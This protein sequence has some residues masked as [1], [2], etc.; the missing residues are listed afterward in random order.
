MAIR[1]LHFRNLRFEYNTENKKL[2]KYESYHNLTV[3][4]LSRFFFVTIFSDAKS[5]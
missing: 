3:R 4:L 5:S 1:A 2:K